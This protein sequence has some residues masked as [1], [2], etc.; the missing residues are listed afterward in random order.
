MF[1]NHYTYRTEWSQEDDAYIATVLEFPLLSGLGETRNEAVQELE[2]A[3]E[4]T[5]AWLKEDGE[6]IPE[7]LSEKEYERNIS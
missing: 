1:K 4:A 5:I 7:P 6:P 3:L 2:I